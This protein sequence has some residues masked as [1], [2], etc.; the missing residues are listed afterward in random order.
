MTKQVL[1]SGG[2][3]NVATFNGPDGGIFIAPVFLG[4]PTTHVRGRLRG[5][6]DWAHAVAAAN[7]ADTFSGNGALS[8]KT[9]EEVKTI[10]FYDGNA[11]AGVQVLETSDTWEEN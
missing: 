7:D 11:V 3:G 6:W 4:D 2:L 10:G 8:T 5:L 1:A 9:F